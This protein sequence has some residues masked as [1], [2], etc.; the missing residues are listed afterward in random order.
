[1]KVTEL[2]EMTLDELRAREMQ[3]AEE[4]ARMRLQLALKR[5]DNPLKIRSTKREL[6][7]VKTIIGARARAGEKPVA[8]TQPA[9]GR[10]KA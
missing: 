2:K 1:M 6:A 4:V 8:P 7:R 3:L 10:E 9:S 5:L